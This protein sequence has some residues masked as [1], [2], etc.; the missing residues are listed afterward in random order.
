M[1]ADCFFLEPNFVLPSHSSIPKFATIIAK[2]YNNQTS[3]PSQNSR[4]ICSSLLPPPTPTTIASS[5]NDLVPLFYGRDASDEGRQ[6]DPAEFIENLTFAIDGQV[7]TDEVRKQTATRVIFRTRLR[8]NALLWYQSL[9]AEVQS[10]CESLE[11]AFL[12]R[13]ALVPRKEVDQTRFLNLVFNLRQRGRSIVQYTRKGDQL[14]AKCLEKFYNVLSHQ[15]IAGLD[16]RGKVDLV[17][18]YLGAKK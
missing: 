4:P 17:Q 7:Y 15:F 13:F 11:V 2:L 16:E 14:N 1:R 5:L 10:N 6:Q 9:P 3:V 18:V 12:T 8:D